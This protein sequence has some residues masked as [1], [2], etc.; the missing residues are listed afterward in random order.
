MN[1]VVVRGRLTRDPSLKESSGGTA[2]CSFSLAINEKYKDKE[3][4]HFFDVTAFG[5]LAEN[6][7]K[8]LEKGSE[9]LIEGKLNYEK[10]TGKDGTER[11]RIGIIANRAEFIG[12]KEKKESEGEPAKDEAPE[13]EA[14]DIPF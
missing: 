1:L 5:S 13:E 6:I 4:V 2:I 14:G 9:I 10:W 11:T 8:Y 12:W 3:K 7:K